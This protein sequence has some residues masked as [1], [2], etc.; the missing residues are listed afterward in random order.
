MASQYVAHNTTT[1]P[2]MGNYLPVSAQT[3]TTAADGATSG[4]AAG[5]QIR[6]RGNLP[7]FVSNYDASKMN[8]I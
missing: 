8:T 7:G 1:A 2:R 4:Y 5:K 6:V 3:L